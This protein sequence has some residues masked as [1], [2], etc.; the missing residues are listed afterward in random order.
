MCQRLHEALGTLTQY[1]QHPGPGEFPVWDSLVKRGEELGL[2][3]M[4]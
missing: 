4:C 3:H 2:V 1:D